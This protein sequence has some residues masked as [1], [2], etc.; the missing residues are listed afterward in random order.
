[1]NTSIAMQGGRSLQPQEMTNLTAFGAT[2]YMDG[3]LTLTVLRELFLRGAPSQRYLPRGRGLTHPGD[4]GADEADRVR[5]SECNDLEAVDFTGCVSAAFVNALT[6]FVT[7]HL[8]PGEERPRKSRRTRFLR[9]VKE[10]PLTIPGLHR[11]GLRGV[12][13]IPPHILNPFVLAFPSLT[14][15]DL[16][17]TRANPELLSALG[18]SLTLRLRS[19]SLARCVALTGDSIRDFLISSP[20]S[21]RIQELSLY[22]DM[23][24]SSPL[25]ADDLRDILTNAPCFTSGQLVYLDVSSSPFTADLVN[26]FK[27]QPKLRSLG[28][29]YIPRLP[30]GAV[31]DFLLCKAPNIEVLTLVSTSPELDC[32]LRA[33]GLPGAVR[34]QARQAS[35]ELH[36]QLIMPLCT[37]PFSFSV[38]PTA[39]AV[40]PL[41]RVRVIELCTPMLAGLGTGASSWRVVRSK[42]G[43]GWYVDTSSGWVADGKEGSVLRRDLEKTHVLRTEL[44][45]LADANGNVTSGIGWHARKMEVRAFSPWADRLRQ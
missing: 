14:H 35:L 4:Q 38:F 41:T 25:S 40:P 3:A 5:F 21:S 19:L 28:L 31:A 30:L 33:G 37:A 17:G 15:L 9:V 6:E 43:R 24:Y 32:G 39:P 20:V 11:L 1:M 8:L 10:E 29:S 16:S 23:T 34:S 18:Q 22:G 7:A 45:R 27:P 42:G 36:A 12:K 44:D 13:S 2:E 26:V